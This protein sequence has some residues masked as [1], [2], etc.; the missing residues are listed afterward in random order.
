[1]SD[2]PQMNTNNP[3]EVNIC[4]RL[5]F[6]LNYCQPSMMRIIYS[7][8]PPFVYSAEKS[9][10]QYQQLNYNI[11]ICHKQYTLLQCMGETTKHINNACCYR[12]HPN[13]QI[14]IEV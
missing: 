6:Y 5:M 11:T 9:M 4:T 1:M 3:L 13:T 2:K 14:H 8:R 7:S 12:K 10:I